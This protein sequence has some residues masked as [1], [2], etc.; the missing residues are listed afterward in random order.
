MN[1]LIVSFYFPPF[2][3]VGA[4]RVGKTAKYLTKMGHQV[5]IIT[6]DEPPLM[7]DLQVELDE[8][9]IVRVPYYDVNAPVQ[10][11]LGGKRS[12]AIKGYERA[13]SL[14]KFIRVLG[15]WYKD[16]VNLPDGQIGWYPFAV[17]AGKKLLSE[18]KADVIL[19]SS[20]PL[21]SFLVARKLSQLYKVPWVAD[22]RDLWA[23]NYNAD[24]YQSFLR[25]ALD[26]KI[27]KYTVSSA[28]ALITVS[29]PLAD[30]LKKKFMQPIGVITNGYD[31]VDYPSEQPSLKTPKVR[32]VYTGTIYPTKKDPTPLF[33]ALV[34]LG[35]EAKNVEVVFYGKNN[36]IIQEL[37]ERYHVE[38]LVQCY[39]TVRYKESLRQQINADLLL[40]LIFNSPAERGVMTAKFFEYLG[41][42]KKILL[43]G[44]V[45]GVAATIIKMHHLGYAENE[46]KKIADILKKY[47]VEKKHDQLLRN[48][49]TEVRE[50]SREAQVEKL[51]KFLEKVVR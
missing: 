30:T 17:Q 26:R 29:Q 47:I 23:D 40:L 19:A 46:P 39:D 50:F 31:E 37:A 16:L 45:D 15:Y 6:A 8:K 2:H 4:I 48:S 22:F 14:P 28:S 51:S 33:E 43:I 21:T 11:L 42:R 12:V 5:K 1:I 27:E 24:L 49:L 35:E 32:I 25:R 36:K 7:S 3:A 13:G 20:P 18:W 9:E 10:W 34:L 41:S 44:C 38:H